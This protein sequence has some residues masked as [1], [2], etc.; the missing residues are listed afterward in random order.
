MAARN[1][2]AAYVVLLA[3]ANAGIRAA[4]PPTKDI[5]PPTIPRI[6]NRALD[7]WQDTAITP[8]TTL[9]AEVARSAM[10]MQHL[11]NQVDRAWERWQ[12][13]YEERKTPDQVASNQRHLREQFIEALGGLP[14]RTPLNARIVGTI[15]REGYRVE[16]V[17][18]ESQPRHYVTAALFLPDVARF[19]PP[20]PG[21][22]VPCGHHVR[23]KAWD[24][25]QSMGAL[26]ALNGMAGLVYDP[27]EQG[28]RRQFPDT[29]LW[30]TT[31]HD[32][33]GIG[34]ILLGRSTAT[35]EIWDGMRSIDYLKSRQ[36]ID[37][38]RIGCT[39]NSGGG[40]QTSYLMALDDRIAAAAPSCYI[41]RLGS[42]IRN[43]YG[44][45][46]QQIFGQLAWGMDH[47]DYLTLQAPHQRV[48]VL[49]ATDDFFDIH[50][51]WRTLRYAKR[52]YSRLGFPERVDILENDAG[53]NYN[54]LQRQGVVRWM[55][56]W[57]LARDQ[58]IDE[59]AINLIPDED[60]RC[61]PGGNVMR[62]EGARS[63]YDLNEEYEKE[64]AARRKQLWATTS[65]AQLLGNVRRVA[66]IR[67]LSELPL[68]AVDKVGTFDQPGYRAERLIL[69]PEPGIYLPALFL[70]PQPNATGAVLYLR[71]KGAASGADTDD[72]VQ[73]WLKA[74]R[75]VLVVDVRG[76]GET[77]NGEEWAQGSPNY[78]AA[79]T[80]YLLG[81]S[82]V[83]L[84]AEDILVCS[85][86]LASQ[87]PSGRQHIDLVA[88]GN[89][90]VPAL[91]AAALEAD[92]FASL[93]LRQTIGSWLE[94]IRARP[95]DQSQLASVVHGALRVYDLPDLSA[96]LGEKLKPVFHSAFPELSPAQ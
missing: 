70:M 15:Q 6:G 37:P 52:L 55:S 75:M 22:L 2:I 19:K 17:L 46:E 38:K 41:S 80:A 56:R 30:G 23:S 48:L 51:A 36:E 83:A 25:Y 92:L 77:G 66:A 78:R 65:R 20:Y 24:E 94:I 64:W 47:P 62:I 93:T 74:G 5:L 79:Y 27:I 58:V 4:E 49:A 1:V 89:I 40:T 12:Q 34:S 91:H 54:N 18:L 86:Y 45:A 87:H 76:T 11:V 32:L 42:Q 82:L 81:R 9:P 3:V 7:Q 8:P 84:R 95:P 35:F 67:P 90:G 53:H 33:I 88:I 21:V 63:T 43:A 57:L 31:A 14:R 13:A 73:A 72:A 61:A 85:R 50:A 28:E 39:G 59:P 10:L 71:E 60:F 16:K 26:L 29:Q 68:P 44:D 69:R 96:I